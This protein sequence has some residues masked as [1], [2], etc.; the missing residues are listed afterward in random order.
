VVKYHSLYFLGRC[1]HATFVAIE[2]ATITAELRY[3]FSSG[4]SEVSNLVRT[5][6][7]IE[8]PTNVAATYLHKFTGDADLSLEG[9]LS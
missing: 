8:Q 9:Q 1:S 7:P 2:L 4:Y 5:V 6:I 3:S